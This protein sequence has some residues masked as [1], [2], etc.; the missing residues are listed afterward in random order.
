MR[1]RL[2]ALEFVGNGQAGDIIALGDGSSAQKDVE[3]LPSELMLDRMLVRGDAAKGQKRGIALNS[4]STTIRNSY[5][6]DIKAFGQESQAIA[7]WNGTGPYTI[8]NNYL[9]AAGVNILF[10]GADPAIPDLVPSDIIIRRNHITKNVG[11]ARIVVDREE[12]A[13]TEERAS[14]AHR[15]QSAGELLD[16]GAARLR[17]PLHGAKLRRPRALGRPS[18]TSSSAATSSSTPPAASISSGT[19]ARQV[20][21]T[22]SGISIENNLFE[23]INHRNGAGTACSS[24]SATRPA[25]VTV[26]H[27]TV[28]QTGNVVTAYGRS[29]GAFITI[30][31]FRFTN[32]VAVHNAYGI[33]G[34]GAGYRHGGHRGVLSGRA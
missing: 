8:E 27:N 6:S 23:D 34:S 7:G 2:L 30:P 5:I 13:R 24:R 18:K 22:A 1:W 17:R 14:R 12:S 21:R 11:L 4:G 28:I 19:T 3:S 16:C 10:G 26:D 9:E 31:G 33:F 25:N 20:S 15:G 29:R 32:N